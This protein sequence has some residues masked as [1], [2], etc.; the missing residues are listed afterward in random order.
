MS[1][2][3]YNAEFVQK[4][5]KDMQKFTGK[6]TVGDGV[7]T[8][9]EATTLTKVTKKSGSQ[10]GSARAGS[11]GPDEL[12]EA[13]AMGDGGAADEPGESDAEHEEENEKQ[14]EEKSR[15]QDMKNLFRESDGTLFNPE[16]KFGIIESESMLYG[17]KTNITTSYPLNLPTEHYQKYI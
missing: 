7:E 10:K 5:E 16:K 9:S 11:P 3:R 17:D 6:T 15:E 13:A 1:T 4:L 8:N 2:N 14:K 12:D